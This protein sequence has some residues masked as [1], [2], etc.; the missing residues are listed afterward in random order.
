MIRIQYLISGKVQGVGFRPFVYKLA[1]NLG[2]VGFIK[3][4]NQGVEIQVQGDKYKL[5]KFEDLL[6]NNLP[7]LANITNIKK[8]SIDI[9]YTGQFEIIQSQNNK[10][11][12]SPFRKATVLPDTAICFECKTDISTNNN[13]KYYKYFATNCTN[14]GPRY[15][16]I[17]TVPYDRINTSMKEFNLCKSCHKEYKNP[18][19][20]RYHAQPTSCKECGPQLELKIKNEE[21]I[22][23]DNEIFHKIPSLIKNGKIGAIKGIG[24]FHIVCDATNDKVVQRLRELKNRPSKP[25]AIMCKD[26]A[27]IKDIAN[28]SK[29]EQE[30]LQSKEAP[31]VILEKQNNNN[32]SKYI[33]PNINKIGCLLPYT[34]LHYLLFEY[35]QNPIVATSANISGEPIITKI[36]DIKEKLPFII[37]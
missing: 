14:C 19:N 28:I 9:L 2:I 17:Q 4:N 27:S 10:S 15:S 1:T 22:I 24:G 12:H 5:E 35:V 18:L 6:Q 21:L 11:K 7:I 20:R 26:I 23:N 3:N 13:S 36:E 34:A 29:K 16:I 30:I 31:I 37:L 33:A 8:N 32:I 25:F